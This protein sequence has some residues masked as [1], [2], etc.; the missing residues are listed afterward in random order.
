MS[1]AQTVAQGKPMDDKRK[2]T[3]GMIT[4]LV[5][6]SMTT[7]LDMIAAAAIETAVGTA[8]GIIIRKALD[9]T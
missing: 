7:V 4:A 2:E 9:R 5:A 3:T 1:P 8:T 6:L